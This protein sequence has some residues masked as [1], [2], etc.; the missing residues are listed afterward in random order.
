MDRLHNLVRISCDDRVGFKQL[1]GRLILST[2]PEAR[3]AKKFPSARLEGPGLLG[4]LVE[5]LP[6]VKSGRCRKA[7]PTAAGIPEA[8]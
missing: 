7:P 8:G 1:T 2:V 3:E 4:L 5:H 6:S